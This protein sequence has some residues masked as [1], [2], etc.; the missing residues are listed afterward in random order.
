MKKIS[1]MIVDDEKLVVKDLTTIVDWGAHGFEIVATAV[2]GR[3]ALAKFQQLRPQVVFT[4]IKMP[5]MDGIELIEH[6]RERDKQTLIVVLTAYE[7]FNYAKT[8][9]QHGIMDYVIKSTID[10]PMASNLLKRIRSQIENQGQVLDILKNKQIEDFFYSDHHEILLAQK[11]LFHKPYCYLLIE[12]N[13]PL[14]LSGDYNIDFIRF[15]KADAI[16]VLLEG[17]N[18]NYNMIAVSSAPRDQ[19]LVVLDIHK[20]SRKDLQQICYQ[21]AIEKKKLLQDFLQVELS[22][23]IVSDKMSLI[24]LKHC[25]EVKRQY[26]NYKYIEYK[27]IYDLQNL[28]RTLSVSAED[29]ILDEKQIDIYIEKRDE[30]GLERYLTELFNSIDSYAKLHLISRALY[31]LL[32]HYCKRMPEYTLQHDLSFDA[33]WRYWTHARRLQAWFMDRFKDLIHMIKCSYQQQYSKIVVQAIHFIYQH[34]SNCDLTLN[35]IADEVQLSVGYL[36][37]IFKKETGNTLNNFITEVRISQAKKL[38][39]DNRLKVYEISSA[40]GFQ[41][42]QYFSQVFYKQVGVYPNEYQKGQSAPQV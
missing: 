12:Q 19:I 29:F 31:D 6:L 1:V 24:E 4:D 35:T 17:D 22:V 30:V 26:F 41:S 11:E 16:S 42:S 14:N 28:Q 15:R 13:M 32:R 2:N 20:N 23:F 33:N 39:E 21:C 27:E 8:A 9:I 34:Y 10:G 18:T 38:L 3:Q 7:D 25:Y 37:V 36:C 40:V 5:F